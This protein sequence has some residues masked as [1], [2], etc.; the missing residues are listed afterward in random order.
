[1]QCLIKLETPERA[2]AKMELISIVSDL[3]PQGKPQYLQMVRYPMISQ[4][5]QTEGKKKMLAVLVLMV[6][7]FCSSVNVVRNMNEDQMIEAGAMLIDECDNFRLEDYTMMFAMAK[8]GTLV[9]I[10]DRVDI[11]VITNIVDAYWQRR[12]DVAAA[13]EED[14]IQRLDSIGCTTRAL[15]TINRV[16]AKMIM[17]TDGLAAG[18]E[19]LRIGLANNGFTTSKQNNNE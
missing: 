2:S 17:A 18:F 14:E 4:L 7:D 11:E 16:D 8:R 5:V 10:F 3:M 19:A 12:K 6:K 9:K 15:E 1:M 13:V